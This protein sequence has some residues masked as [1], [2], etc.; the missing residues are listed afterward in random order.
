MDRLGQ[1]GE[2]VVG[3]RA[4][5]VFP[6]VDHQ[7]ISAVAGR[8]EL[9]LELVEALEVHPLDVEVAERST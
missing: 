6:H 4:A 3:R 9:F 2:Q 7:A 1:D 8:V 5:A